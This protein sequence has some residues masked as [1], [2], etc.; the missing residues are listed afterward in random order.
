MSLIDN[1]SVLIEKHH[2][3][4]NNFQVCGTSLEAS[5]K[6]YGYR[7]DSIYDEVLRISSGLTR[8]KSNV[9]IPTI[10]LCNNFNH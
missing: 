9:Y 4:L 8:H 2:K 1:F 10:I 5:S 7:V 6:I 3:S